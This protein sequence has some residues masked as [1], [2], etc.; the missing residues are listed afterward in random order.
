M[1]LTLRQMEAFLAVANL[2]S[3]T[4]AGKSL[5]ITQSATSALVKELEEQ[6]GLCLFDRTSRYVALSPDGQNF[7]PIVQKAFQECMLAE[8]F[9][10][11]MKTQRNGFVRV[12]GAPLIACTLLPLIIAAFAYVAPEIHVH[13]VDQPMSLLQQSVVK[14]DAD[15]GFG[16]ERHL[17][18]DIC[19]QTFF[20]TP[21]SVVCR[22][23]HPFVGHTPH[24]DNV[25]HEPFIAVGAETVARLEAEVGG[26]VPFNV[27]HVVDQMSTAFALVAAR[28][29]IV[30]AGPFCM[31]LARGYGLTVTPCQPV[32]LRNMLLYTHQNRP[33]APAA[34][35]FVDFAMTFVRQ[36]DPNALT[37]KSLADLVDTKNMDT[38]HAPKQDVQ[39]QARKA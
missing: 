16:P 13:I 35:T 27:A 8:R 1:Y 18:L 19:A 10:C 38:I 31:L 25:K 6:I 36:H 39:Y 12:V 17:E 11:A 15:V 9:A 37:N 4:A 2:R 23:D 5:H 30:V 14:G 32:V 34:A 3:F 21:V 22:K 20:T 24:W 26:S 29:G 33:L 28:R 7:F